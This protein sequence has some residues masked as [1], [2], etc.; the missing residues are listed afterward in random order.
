MRHRLAAFADAALDASETAR[1]EAHLS[2]CASCRNALDRHDAVAAL[3][4]QMALVEAPSGIWHSLESAL[5]RPSTVNVAARR[6]VRW[7]GLT[8]AAVALAIVGTAGAW[9]AMTRPAAWDVVRLDQRL[10]AR[11]ADGQWL[12]TD[13]TSTAALRIGEIGRVDLAPG[14]RLQLVTARPGEHRLNLARGRISVEILA[15]PRVFFVETPASTVVDL[16]CAYTMDV[17]ADGGGM[18]RVTQGWAALEWTDRESLV[19]AGASARSHPSLGPGT[20]SFDDA[21][22]GLR[23]ALDELDFGLEKETALTVVLAEARGRDTLTLWHLMS[24][25]TPV[26]RVRVFE[27]LV[28]LTPLPDGVS[29]DGAL[30]LD[31]DTMRHWREELA[32][33]W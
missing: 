27:R 23:R 8:L 29:R 12:E 6:R 3:L 17:E 13:P 4:R 7:P 25:V 16:G 28:S 18:L 9:W 22:E 26:E 31:T 24:R 33:T 19:P 10:A 32:W 30:A 21:T 11:V 5:D 15:P 1:V 2:A 20:P 14:T